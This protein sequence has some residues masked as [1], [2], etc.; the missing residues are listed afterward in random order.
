MFLRFQSGQIGRGCRLMRCAPSPA[1]TA[2]IAA[3]CLARRRA[4]MPCSSWASRASTARRNSARRNCCAGLS[5]VRLR[6]SLHGG[7]L[8]RDQLAIAAPGTAAHPST[9][10]RAACYRRP[11]W[12]RTTVPRRLGP[13]RCAPP[14][15]GFA[16]I[17]K[18]KPHQ[19]G[20]DHQ[21]QRGSRHQCHAREMTLA[22]YR[23]HVSA[24]HPRY[25]GPGAFC[26]CAWA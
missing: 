23:A 4:A 20:Y 26:P 18:V 22:I 12:W 5:R 14:T 24:Q 11:G 6:S 10:N 21:E 16:R 15:F 25:T 2:S 8:R 7:R 19:R 9:S 13:G 1:R 3:G 17:L